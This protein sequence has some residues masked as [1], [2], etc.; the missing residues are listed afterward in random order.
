LQWYP[1]VSDDFNALDAC[2]TTF[3]NWNDG[4]KGRSLLWPAHCFKDSILKN[5]RGL[6]RDQDGSPSAARLEAYGP[7]FARTVPFETPGCDPKLHH[8]IAGEALRFDLASFLSPQAEHRAFAITHD[9]AAVRT[10]DEH[11]RSP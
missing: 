1:L 3:P 10:T 6:G 7:C 11:R 4:G 9:D 8:Q 2:S 5:Y